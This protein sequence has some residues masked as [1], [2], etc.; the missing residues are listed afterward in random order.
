MAETIPTSL[1]QASSSEVM[2]DE[3]LIICSSVLDDRSEALRKV[4]RYA[5]IFLEHRVVRENAEEGMRIDDLAIKASTMDYSNKERKLLFT[6]EI[7]NFRFDNYVND[8]A[9]LANK[10]FLWVIEAADF[11]QM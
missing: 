10:M 4:R 5:R 11:D 1:T 3:H 9:L 2:A 8:E 7:N 6:H